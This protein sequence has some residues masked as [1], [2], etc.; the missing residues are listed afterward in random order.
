MPDDGRTTS[1]SAGV[2]LLRARERLTCA[3]VEIDV[4]LD[5]TFAN[6]FCGLVDRHLDSA[7][8]ASASWQARKPRRWGALLILAGHDGA[9]E[10]AKHGRNIFIVC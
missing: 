4:F 6:S 10:R 5:L 7:K 2:G 9:P 8:P 3:T 1:V